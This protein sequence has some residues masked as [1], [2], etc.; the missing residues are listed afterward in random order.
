MAN[1]KK[2]YQILN[3]ELDEVLA[4]LQS[5]ELDIDEATKAYEHGMEIVKELE[6]YLK[7]AEN[8]VRKLTTEPKSSTKKKA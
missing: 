1:S 8:T 2:S 5:G 4:K 7:S 6:T 3:N